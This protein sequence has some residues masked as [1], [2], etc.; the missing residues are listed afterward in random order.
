MTTALPASYEKTTDSDI[1]LTTLNGVLQGFPANFLQFEI[2]VQTFD[3]QIQSLMSRKQDNAKV[4]D[5]ASGHCPA[6]LIRQSV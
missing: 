3:S 6:S 4:P 5:V 2:G 1:L